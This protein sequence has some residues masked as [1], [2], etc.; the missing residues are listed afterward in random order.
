MFFPF[1]PYKTDMYFICCAFT[2]LKVDIRGEE[3][4]FWTEW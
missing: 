3:K 1:N 2:F 4:T